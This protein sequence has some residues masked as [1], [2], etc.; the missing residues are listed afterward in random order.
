M[1]GLSAMAFLDEPRYEVRMR[2]RSLLWL[3]AFVAFVLPP[4]VGPVASMA[5]SGHQG[6]SD[7]DHA[8]PPPC[9]DKNSAKHA[10]GLC[11]PL[12]AQ[13]LATLPAPIDTTDLDAAEHGAIS[14]TARYVGLSP[15]KDPPPPRA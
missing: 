11:C 15:H 8:P 5:M 3:L 10:A 1:C 6:A 14:T 2:L 13:V 9:P 4:S 12:M 7:C